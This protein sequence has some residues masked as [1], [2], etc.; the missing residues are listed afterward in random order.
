MIMKK[1]I[2]IILLTIFSINLSFAKDENFEEHK[3]RVSEICKKSDYWKIVSILKEE[4][5]YDDASSSSDASWW[6]EALIKAKNAYRENMNN[7]YKCSLLKVQIRWIEHIKEILSK[8]DK[9]WDLLKNIDAKLES[10]K[11]K[12]KAKS[13]T[14]CKNESSENTKKDDKKEILN[15]VTLQTCTYLSYLTYLEKYVENIENITKNNANSNQSSVTDAV[16][17]INWTNTIAWISKIYS[18][19]ISDIQKEEKNT[20]NIFQVAF[21]SYIE[22]ESN[23]VLHVLLQ[24]LKEDYIVFREKL[25]SVIN[26]INQLVYKI[27]NA[28]TK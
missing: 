3:T 5:T 1:I 2:S 16:N 7:I 21:Q 14:L 8:T 17:K 26:P 25:N 20:T 12:L 22:Y 11:N 24:L 4:K 19:M 6:A 23:Y 15:N 27:S 10:N 28:M 18:N 13:D 9:T